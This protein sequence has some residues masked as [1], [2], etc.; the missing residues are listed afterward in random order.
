MTVNCNNFANLIPDF[1][2]DS[3]SVPDLSDFLAHLDEC[4]AC[5]EELSTQYLLYE[6]LTRLETGGTFD[7]EKELEEVKRAARKR[8]ARRQ[9]LFSIAAALEIVTLALAIVTAY[10]FLAM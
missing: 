2:T 4:P 8:L 10:V 7:L 5:Q 6:G 9:R 3:L 1:L